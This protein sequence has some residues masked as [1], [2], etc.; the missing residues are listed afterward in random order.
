MTVDTHRVPVENC[1]TFEVIIRCNLEISA[2]SPMLWCAMPRD[3]RLQDD[4]L[5]YQSTS[6]IQQLLP[7]HRFRTSFLN[8]TARSLGY[9][10]KKRVSL[11][12][13]VFLG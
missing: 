8:G 12:F 4:S 11:P 7:S 13:Q 1:R 5:L 2:I 3:L 10:T 9:P 6:L